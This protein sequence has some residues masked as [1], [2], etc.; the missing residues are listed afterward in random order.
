MA[1]VL[2]FLAIVAGCALLL[3]VAYRMEPHWVS[4]DGERLVCYG[5][6]LSRN[7]NA[8]SRWREVRVL[9]VRPDTVE[10]RQRRGG[11]FAT[12]SRRD[13]LSNPMHVLNRRRPKTSYWKVLGR[14]ETPPRRRVV[15]L[16]DGSHDPNLPD[17]LA[18]R[19]PVH[20]RAIPMLDAVAA[21]RYSAATTRPNRETPQ[22]VEPP[23]RD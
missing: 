5:Q 9:R 11:G 19:L 3:W 2:T 15:F 16:L 13:A 14:S 7:G 20:S 12:T 4:K 8:D 17:M 21:N 23:D 6:G 1:S 18:L 22:S 10:V